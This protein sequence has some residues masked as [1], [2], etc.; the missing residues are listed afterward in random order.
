M[1]SKTPPPQVLQG[2][3]KEHLD[4][5]PAIAVTGAEQTGKSTLA[6][7]LTPGWQRFL[8]VDDLPQPEAEDSTR[9]ASARRLRDLGE[10]LA[11]QDSANAVSVA[12]KSANLIEA[13]LRTVPA[14]S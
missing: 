11:A 13:H 10:L 7:E 2:I 6:T 9:T 1:R 3:L 5:M 14:T 8:S 12:P 4:T